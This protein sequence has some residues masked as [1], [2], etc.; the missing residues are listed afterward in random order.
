MAAWYQ[1]MTDKV[2]GDIAKQ[3][4]GLLRDLGEAGGDGPAPDAPETGPGPQAEAS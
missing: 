2:R 3:V 4:G 1:H